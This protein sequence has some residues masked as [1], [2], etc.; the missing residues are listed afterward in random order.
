[1]PAQLDFLAELLAGGDFLEGIE[2]NIGVFGAGA[3]L[4]ENG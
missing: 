2:K 3:A 1:V 4:F